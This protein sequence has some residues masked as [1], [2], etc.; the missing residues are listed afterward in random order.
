MNDADTLR[1]NQGVLEKNILISCQNPFI[2]KLV[3]SFES[4]FYLNLLMEYYP[5]GELFFHLQK[6]KFTE[7]EVKLYFCEIVLAFEYL[8]FK[9]I[10]YRD[11]KVIF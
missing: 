7:S 6:K 8:H 11:I 3:A 9:K 1:L 5:G 2:T 4:E 10:L